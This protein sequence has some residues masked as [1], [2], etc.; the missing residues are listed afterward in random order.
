MLNVPEPITWALE[1]YDS[2]VV[3][4]KCNGKD[5]VTVKENFEGIME[6]IW[7]KTYTDFLDEYGLDEDND[8]DELPLNREDSYPV[9]HCAVD[10]FDDEECVA[11]EFS[12]LYIPYCYGDFCEVSMACDAVMDAFS[13]LKETISEIFCF[14]GLKHCI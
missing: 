3:V 9:V 8:N 11:V 2:S 4:I 13:K 5:P 1:S 10:T 14:I 7:D 6:D 12:P